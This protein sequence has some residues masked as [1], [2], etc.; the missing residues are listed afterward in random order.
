M[1]K[2]HHFNAI[3]I[4]IF[5]NINH[6]YITT[7]RKLV[8]A[9]CAEDIET[10][11][12]FYASDVVFRDATMKRGERKDLETVK[13]ELK[14]RFAMFDDIDMK[15]T[16]YPDC[17]YYALNDNYVVYSWWIH[18]ATIASTGE[19]HEFPIML[20]HYFDKDGKIVSEI[21]YYSTNHFEEQ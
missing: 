10:M 11:S 7:V 21:A 18:S 16:G 9:Y 1:E 5:S 20:S 14:E 13:G 17:I 12:S 6:P 8:N 15:Q 4:I 19:K 2:F 3:L